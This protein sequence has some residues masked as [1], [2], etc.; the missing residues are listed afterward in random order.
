MRVETTEGN[1]FIFCRV[2]KAAGGK[3]CTLNVGQAG[4]TNINQMKEYESDTLPAWF[5][6]NQIEPK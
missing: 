6:E 2:M 5:G 3:T 1:W 4:E